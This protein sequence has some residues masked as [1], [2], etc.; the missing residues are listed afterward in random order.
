M[1]L[2]SG[3]V[4]NS[5][6]DMT[7][8]RTGDQGI[9]ANVQDKG[10]ENVAPTT[11]LTTVVQLLQQ[12]NAN[13]NSKLDSN[14]VK[15]DASIEKINKIEANNIELNEKIDSVNLQLN[16]KIDT[17]VINLEKDVIKK[18]IKEINNEVEKIRNDVDQVIKSN[19]ENIQGTIS[20]IDK[21]HYIN[22]DN[23][24]KKVDSETQDIRAQ[25][26][27]IK[28][29]SNLQYMCNRIPQVEGNVLFYGDQKVHPKV[30]IKNLQEMIEILP[31]G[32]NI[33]SYI[34]DRLKNDAE[35]WY[36]IVEEKYNTFNEFVDLFLSNFWGEHQ[37]SKIR[38]NLFNGKYRENV[39]CTREKYIL[40]KYNYVRH[41]EPRMPDTEIVKYLSRHFAEDIRDVILIQGID[42]IERMLQYLRRIDDAKGTGYQKYGSGRDRQND[43]GQAQGNGDRNDGNGKETYYGNNRRYGERWNNNFKRNE[44]RGNDYRQRNDERQRQDNSKKDNTIHEE[45][46]KT[47]WSRIHEITTAMV[48]PNPPIQNF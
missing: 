46:K 25:I 15:L 16:K 23:L 28:T 9:Q 19:I 22:I 10:D 37:Q 44:N 7:D 24:N 8:N 36:S 14:T 42:T 3:K 11:D 31:E 41:L 20:D 2:K 5:T 12:M 35:I 1:K 33:K 40:K 43:N 21:Q 38:E 47:E 27:N 4:T 13:L 17:I 45:D 29:V 39:G 48:E 6:S 34:R 30:F 26:S 32:S 18:I